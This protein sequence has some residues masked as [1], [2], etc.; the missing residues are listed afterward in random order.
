MI[1]LKTREEI[2]AMQEGGRILRKVVDA[3][4]KIIKVGMSTQEIDDRAERL[5][6]K[7]GGQSSF[8]QVKDYRWSTC[9]PV[10]EEIVHTPP[11]KRILENGDVLTLDIGVYFKGFHTDFAETFVVGGSKDEKIKKFLQVGEEALYKA[12]KKLKKGNRLGDVS[13]TIEEE[14]QGHGYFVIKQLT[15]HGIGRS[16]HEDPYVLGYLDRPVNQTQ[17][18]KPG[19]TVAIEVIYSMGTEEMAHSDDGSWTIRTKDGSL[20][21]CFEH[22]LAVTD[23]DTVILT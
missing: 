1:D 17:I 20:S 6:K 16:L 4:K 18:I 5:I 15:G 2:Q 3:L 13:K 21:A 12:I 19:L 10:N 8:N 22:S 7:F 23:Q 14:I 11:S 9:L